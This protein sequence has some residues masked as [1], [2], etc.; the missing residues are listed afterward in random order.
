MVGS[1]GGSLNCV[2]YHVMMPTYVDGNKCDMD[3]KMRIGHCLNLLKSKPDS[4]N[5]SIAF[6]A[7]GT[8]GLGY[9]PDVT[10]RFMFSHVESWL[11]ANPD[12]LKRVSFVVFPTDTKTV[13]GLFLKLAISMYFTLFYSF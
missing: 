4:I 11:L 13:Q 12:G 8:G 9:P 7:L 3:M 2:I 10:A 6:P 1:S 5:R